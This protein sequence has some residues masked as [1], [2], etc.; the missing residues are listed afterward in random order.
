M[1]EKYLEV[2]SYNCLRI[3]KFGREVFLVVEKK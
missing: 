2:D 3:L 1:V